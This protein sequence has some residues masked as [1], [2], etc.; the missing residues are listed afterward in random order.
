LVKS[1]DSEKKSDVAEAVE[2]QVADGV[3]LEL[4]SESMADKNGEQELSMADVI[5]VSTAAAKQQMI[6]TI[7]A[8]AAGVLILG[9]GAVALVIISKKKKAGETPIE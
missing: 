2:T 7:V 5:I 1:D 4:S 3:I 6:I 9:G 8:I